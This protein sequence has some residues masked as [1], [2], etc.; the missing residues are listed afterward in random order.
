M[1]DNINDDKMVA[2][3]KQSTQNQLSKDEKVEYVVGV[4][5]SLSPE[6][7]VEF[8]KLKEANKNALDNS[9]D[10]NA[11]VCDYI[12]AKRLNIDLDKVHFKYE[13]FNHPFPEQD[14]SNVKD[15]PEADKSNLNSTYLICHADKVLDLETIYQLGRKLEELNE[16][17]PKIKTLYIF[18]SD[19]NGNLKKDEVMGLKIDSEKSCVVKVPTNE[20][21]QFGKELGFNNSKNNFAL[22]VQN[23]KE[24]VKDRVDGTKKKAIEIY[25]RTVDSKGRVVLKSKEATHEM[26][27]AF[28]RGLEKASLIYTYKKEAI[29]EF[30]RSTFK[31]GGELTDEVKND[32]QKK[33]E[34]KYNDLA[35]RYDEFDKEKDERFDKISK[36]LIQAKINLQEAIM[37]KFRPFVRAKEAVKAALEAGKNS[38]KMS[39]EN[40]LKENEKLSLK[41]KGQPKV[42]MQQ[43]R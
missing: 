24:D 38:W 21:E 42:N 28:L 2:Y 17:N 41:V 14:V 39:K 11:R 35:S 25:D 34:D 26:K 6:E 4:R 20:M 31:K 9:L 30:I 13:E 29:Q 22:L 23:L 16:L 27:N 36:D 19:E 32:I 18:G 12:M 3:F 7:M 15:T 37:S 10:V 33:A 5:S 1:A 43:E 8:D 40:M